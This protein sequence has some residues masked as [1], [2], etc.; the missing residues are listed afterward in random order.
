MSLDALFQHILFTEQQAEESRRLMREVRSET[1]RCRERIQK[2]TEELNQEKVK[3]ASKVEQFYEKSFLLEHLKTHQNALQRQY[4]EITKQRNVLLQNFEV[5][6]KKVEEEEEKFLKEIT[7]FNNKYA[8]TNK[9]ELLIKENVKL[10][11]SDLEN[12]ANI[13]KM[14]MKSM[15]QDG[16]QLNAL[17]KQK[18]DLMQE[19]FILQRKLKVFEEKEK[20]AICTTNYLEA[21]K[22]KV[23]EKPKNDAECLRLKKE[24][25]LYK[26]DDM[27]SIYEALQT[28]VQFLKLLPFG[29]IKHT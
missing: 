5:I 22:I 4:S 26:E 14:E 9:R 15:E 7:D 29:H 10:E 24:I 18:H 12:Q 16:C 3:L 8:I 21:E 20:E 2:A 17:H 27:K 11:I 13:L 6:K 25:D 19:L 23:N 28:E 1:I